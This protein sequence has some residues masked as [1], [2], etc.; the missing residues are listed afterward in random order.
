[1]SEIDSFIWKFRKL[2]HSGN[3]A[4]LEIRSEAGKATVNLTAEV[5]IPF[6]PQFQSRNGPARQR[7][8]ERRA[9]ERAAAA[10]EDA[11]AQTEDAVEAES[12]KARDEA[13][14]FKDAVE[15]TEL[16]AAR[17]FEPS[18]EISNLN[19]YDLKSEELATAVSIVPIRRVGRNDDSIEKVR[20]DKFAQNSVRIL[21]ISIHRSVDGIFIRSYAR[22]EPTIGKFLD[23]TDFVFFNCRVIPIFGSQ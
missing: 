17:A 6:K 13:D 20:K 9:A 14:T 19:I 18:D 23:E 22:I 10:A 7:R 2:L 5:E 12:E 11:A 16:E 4:H 1:M 3:N 15:A 8:R 21:E